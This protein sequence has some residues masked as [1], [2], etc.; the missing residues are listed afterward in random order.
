MDEHAATDDR[1][2]SGLQLEQEQF[3][4]P[5][6]L[7]ARGEGDQK[8]TSRRSGRCR[9]WL[10]QSLSVTAMTSLM[11]MISR[12]PPLSGRADTRAAVSS[13]GNDFP[14]DLAVPAAYSAAAD[15]GLRN[16]GITPSATRWYC[17][18]IICSGVPIGHERLISSIPG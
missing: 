7:K 8:L 18:S 13:R 16:A 5:Q 4:R 17:S 11:P 1:W 9:R 3:A 14:G 6:A 10:N 12:L 2:T 15:A